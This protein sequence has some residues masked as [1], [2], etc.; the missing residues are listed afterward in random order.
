MLLPFVTGARPASRGAW[1]LLPA[2]LF[3][4]AALTGCHN[5]CVA[6]TS[7][8]GGTLQIK[9]G[10]TPPSCTLSKA[11]A[12]VRVALHAAPTCQACAPSSRIA[13]I[14]VSL[15]GIELHP[16]TIADDASPDWLEVAPQLVKQPLQVDLMSGAA[17]AGAPQVLA[18]RIFIPAGEY[19]QVRLR[20]V[21][22]RPAADEQ[23]PEKNACGSAGFNCVVMADGR[24][25]P[26]LLDDAAPEL[27]ITSDRIAGG[28]LL[29]P[30]D[31]SA[32]LAIEFEPFWSLSSSAAGAIRLL[33][34]L[35][36]RAHLTHNPL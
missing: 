15:R 7:N 1:F 30:P 23:L 24:I 3:F 14:F 8:Q 22:N 36:P 20:L 34:A 5:T 21:S 13:H 2:L 33:P 19:R 16:S 6:F 35:A 26:L 25:Q 28:F 18:E 27:R 10:S 17:A 32:E 31:S 12:A 29:F 9:A 4:A 11:N